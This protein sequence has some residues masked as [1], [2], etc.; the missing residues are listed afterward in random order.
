MAGCPAELQGGSFSNGFLNSF[1]TSSAAWAYKSV[2]GQGPNPRTATGKYSHDGTYP[3]DEFSKVVKQNS[4]AFGANDALSKTGNP[5]ADFFSNF[6][7]QEGFVSKALAYNVPLANAVAFLHDRWW[8]SV[9]GVP[10]TYLGV[11]FNPATNY[12][13]M[14]PAAAITAGAFL[15]DSYVGPVIDWADK[16]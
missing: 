9:N 16:K 10:T 2:V 15:A 3:V 14:L 6:G 8:N 11:G 7:K 1:A 13:T 4:N 5:V 12:G